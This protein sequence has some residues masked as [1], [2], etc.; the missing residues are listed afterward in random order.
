MSSSQSQAEFVQEI[1]KKI[2]YGS[3]RELIEKLFIQSLIDSYQRIDKNIGFENEI[4]DRFMK[5]LYQTNSK[6]KQWLQL[7]WID[8][9]WE[10][11]VFTPEF[12]LARTD[13]AF[14][15][16]GL[17]FIIECKKLKSPAKAYIDEGLDRFVKLQYAEGDEYGG[18][19]GFVI[20]G[21]KSTISQKLQEKIAPLGHTNIIRK[22]AAEPGFNSVHSRTNKSQIELYHLFFDFNSR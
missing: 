13:I 20:K 14:K 18:M 7:K 3:K 8:L 5:D 17:H 12:Q 11:W 16:T 2:G 6:I 15:L 21:D 9:I 10:N 4:R 1:I 22:G 19:I